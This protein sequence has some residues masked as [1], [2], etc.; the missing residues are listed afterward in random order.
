MFPTGSISTNP[1]SERKD[2]SGSPSRRGRRAALALVLLLLSTA[3]CNPVK[4]GVKVGVRLFGEVIEDEDVQRRGE[5]LVGRPITV[6]DEMFGSPIDA[7]KDEHGDRRWQTYP[8]KLDLL[9]HQRYVV[10]V[11]GGKVVSV[12]K[13]EPSGRKVDIPR[14]LILEGKVKGKTPQQCAAKL[15]FGSPLLTAR[16]ENTGR[17]V[18]IYDAGMMTDLGTP[19]YCVVRFDEHDLC[20]DLEFVAVGASTKKD[21]AM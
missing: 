19:H 13:A 4:T 17:L 9:G 7:F 8:V 11:V 12:S 5:E 16:S 15:E 3:G 20:N 2:A 21:P 18:Q 14:A 1:R 6:V 10:E